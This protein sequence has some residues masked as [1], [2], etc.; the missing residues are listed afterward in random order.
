MNDPIAILLRASVHQFIGRLGKDPET[1]YLDNGKCVTNVNI[2]VNWLPDNN[3]TDWIKLEIWGE[4]GQ[5][6]ADAARKGYLVQVAGRVKT[7]RWTDRSTGEEK[8]QLCCRVE[9]W[10]VLSAPQGG[11]AAPPAAAPAPAAPAYQPQ[12]AAPAPAPAYAPAPAA[13]A[14]APSRYDPPF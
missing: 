8:M 6:F 10:K 2:G 5:A 9:S 4:A 12:P 14:V 13:P 1:R 7:D 11:Q 3:Q